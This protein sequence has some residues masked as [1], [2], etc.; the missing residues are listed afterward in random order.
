M[1]PDPRWVNAATLAGPVM[2]LGMIGVYVALAI[3]ADAP[4]F[5]AVLG[6]G[7]AVVAMARRRKRQ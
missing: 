6:V 2:L 5:W 3:V 7:I 4:V 1:K